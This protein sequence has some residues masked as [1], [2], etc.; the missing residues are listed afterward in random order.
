MEPSSLP[1]GI[2]TRSPL[3][4]VIPQAQL[5]IVKC[6]IGTIPIL[7]RKRRDHMVAKTID[8]VISKDIQQEVSYLIIVFK[9]I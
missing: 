8:E 1:L 7:R 2:H 5:P 9:M 6:P 4:D 3:D